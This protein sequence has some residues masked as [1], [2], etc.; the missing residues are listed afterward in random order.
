MKKCR[1][2]LLYIERRFC[3]LYHPS[4]VHSCN[5]LEVSPLKWLIYKVLISLSS[6]LEAGFTTFGIRALDSR[7]SL[8]Q[9]GHRGIF[10][11]TFF[12]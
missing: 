11:I 4:I 7:V 6:L 8:L 1:V 9:I 10:T 5:V 12:L 2:T 3:H